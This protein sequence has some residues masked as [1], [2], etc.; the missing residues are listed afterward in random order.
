MTFNG[1]SPPAYSHPAP[2]GASAPPATDTSGP[3]ELAPPEAPA[4]TTPASAHAD[5]SDDEAAL[6]AA[7]AELDAVEAALARLEDGS[8]EN[9]E[10]CGAPIGLDRLTADPL[11]TRCAQHR[12]P[13]GSS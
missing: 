4:P 10:V 7:S 9:C 11:L 8:F 12:E 1:G 3:D 2:D 5:H 6:A 13:D